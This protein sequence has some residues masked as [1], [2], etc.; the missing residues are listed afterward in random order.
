MDK[1]FLFIFS[2]WNYLS[3]DFITRSVP[4]LLSNS[5]FLRED[6]VLLFEKGG[7]KIEGKN[8]KAAECQWDT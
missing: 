7:K 1:S 6:E 2:V 3:T 4:S 8:D 5:S